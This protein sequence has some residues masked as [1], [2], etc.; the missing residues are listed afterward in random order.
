[1][2]SIGAAASDG[3]GSTAAATGWWKT[4]RLWNGSTTTIARPQSSSLMPGRA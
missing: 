3:R 1:M 2:S 4:S